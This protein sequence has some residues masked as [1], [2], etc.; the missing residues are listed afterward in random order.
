[1][2]GDRS[3]LIYQAFAASIEV[4]GERACRALI[5]DL[6]RHGIHQDNVTL[7]KLATGLRYVMGDEATDLIIQ[8][9][10]IKLDKMY[11]TRNRDMTT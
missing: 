7:E 10:M 11:S 5:E 2:P 3:E 9:V 6:E 4:L 8:E 1:M